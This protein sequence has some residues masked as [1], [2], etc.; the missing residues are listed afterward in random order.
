M[1]EPPPPELPRPPERAAAV[2]VP[3]AVV[4]YQSALLRYVGNLLGGDGE[5]AQDVVQEV[6]LRLHRHVCAHGPES[7]ANPQSWLFRVAHNLVMDHGRQRQ[8]E[9]RLQAAVVANG[10]GR[11]E[12]AAAADE[13]GLD[14]LEQREACTRAMAELSRLPED[15]KSVLLLKI[16]QGLTLRE[17]AEVTGL[18][19]GNAGYR[20]NQ[21]LRELS[22]RLKEQ[23]VI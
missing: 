12:S 16:V 6:F 3:A 4:R 10:R 1:S 2:D 20:L 14:D 15:L 5:Q 23:G 11:E 21:G 13:N 7:V 17:V 18:T 22:R 8:R 19:V 9:D